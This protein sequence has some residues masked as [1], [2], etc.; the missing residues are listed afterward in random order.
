MPGTCNMP[1]WYPYYPLFQYISLL[2]SYNTNMYVHSIPT[3]DGRNP[4][5]SGMYETLVNNRI[6]YQPQLVSLPDFW[7]INSTI[8]SI[9]NTYFSPLSLPQ[10]S[11]FGEHFSNFWGLISNFWGLI[12]N[13]WGLISNFWGLISNFSDFGSA[14]R[15]MIFEQPGRTR[16]FNGRTLAGWD[17]EDG[18]G[19]GE[20]IVLGM[21]GG[22][23][24]P[25]IYKKW[26]GFEKMTIDSLFKTKFKTVEI[27]FEPLFE[28]PF[29]SFF[30]GLWCWWLW[31]MFFLLLLVVNNIFGLRKFL[32]KLL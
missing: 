21:K 1:I 7:T 28:V 23:L 6:N 20:G 30:G 29:C 14:D 4:A 27:E 16:L 13:F 31:M 5:P 24:T 32:D 22:V 19:W 15:E 9:W 11:D 12:S 26:I 10:T 17:V 3:L 25:L 8:L 2:Y 18:G